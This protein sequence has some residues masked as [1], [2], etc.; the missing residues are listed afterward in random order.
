MEFE[1]QH[2]WWSFLLAEAVSD[3]AE[4]D[5]V[6]PDRTPRW[7]RGRPQRDAHQ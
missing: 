4:H 5:D 6:E 1:L 3:D 7:F 2:Q